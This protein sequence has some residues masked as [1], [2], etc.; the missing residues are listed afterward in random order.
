MPTLPENF[1]ANILVGVIIG[2]ILLLIEYRTGW[3][4]A[5]TRNR[6]SSTTTNYSSPNNHAE[7][8]NLQ[9]PEPIVSEPNIYQQ[10]PQESAHLQ[11]N[12][13]GL[14]SSDVDSIATNTALVVAL[15]AGIISFLKLRQGLPMTLSL[16]SRFYIAFVLSCIVASAL[17]VGTFG[18]F[19]KLLPH[20]FR[21]D[22]GKRFRAEDPYNSIS[23]LGALTSGGIAFIVLY[24]LF[25]KF[26]TA[27]LSFYCSLLPSCCLGALVPSILVRFAQTV[28]HSSVRDTEDEYIEQS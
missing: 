9:P 16:E 23:C 15:V 4:A 6:N 10:L 5:R 20:H 24:L 2:V 13:A 28:S 26:L 21:K 22:F 14:T 7:N 18:T 17:G 12:T 19:K 3:F 11:T 1:A 25:E 27:D 8:D